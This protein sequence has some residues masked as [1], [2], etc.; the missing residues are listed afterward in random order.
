MSQDHFLT[1]KIRHDIINIQSD[2]IKKTMA[3]Q[4][5]PTGKE[6][7][8]KTMV[9]KRYKEAKAFFVKYHKDRYDKYYKNANDYNG[10]RL[11][12][13]KKVG[14][15]DWMSNL[16]VPITASHIRTIHPRVIG[17]LPSIMV[18]GRNQSSQKG[19]I[20]IQAM[21]EYLWERNTMK[22]KIKILILD[23]INY[24]IGIGKVI[25]DKGIVK[26]GMTKINDDGESEF[27]PMKFDEYDDPGF[28]PVDPY[29]Y[30]HDP[31]GTTI[32][33]CRYHFQ[34]YLLTADQ[35][36]ANYAGLIEHNIEIIKSKDK[37]IDRGDLTNY[38]S[39]RKD[40][41]EYKSKESAKNT[42]DRKSV[43]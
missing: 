26:G 29:S 2:L 43:V 27:V 34:R 19:A 25:W 13:L 39:V 20:K 5:N 9:E 4:Y 18:S 8:I 28:E 42:S 7:K 33:N 38:A 17:G 31:L 36:Q 32:D 10:D 1:K 24:G 6:K 40:I 11:E 41:L 15:D 22:G 12:L 21:L 35:I 3:K 37:S 14:G 23:A 16:F 30:F